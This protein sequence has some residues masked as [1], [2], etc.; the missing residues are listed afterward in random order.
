MHAVE[1]GSLRCLMA[2]LRIPEVDMETEDKRGRS[3]EEVAR[4]VEDWSWV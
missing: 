1:Q 3:L 4:W 2:L